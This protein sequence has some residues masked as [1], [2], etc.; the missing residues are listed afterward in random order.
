MDKD[1]YVIRVYESPL[2]LEGGEW[3]ALLARQ[4]RPTPFMRHE[5]L[6]ALH[7]SGSATPDTGWTPRFLALRDAGGV[8][9]A[10]C[11]LYFKRHS[12]GE[13]VFDWGW[14]EAYARHGLPY[15]PKAVVAVPFTPVPGSRLLAD[16]D[17]WR[18][19]LAEAARDTCASAGAS[20]L[21]L[22][23]GSPEDIT[24]CLQAGLMRRQTVQFHW[25]NRRPQP[26]DSFED[27]LAAL[28][29]DKR[30]KIRQER[31]KVQAAGVTVQARVGDGIRAQDWDFFYACYSRT[32]EEHGNPPYL[33]RAFFGGLAREQAR[34]WVLFTA[35]LEGR[36]IACSLVAFDDAPGVSAAWGRY[37]GAL[38]RVDCLH[39]ELCYYAPLQ[40][41]IGR[42]LG[43][44]EGGAQGEHKLARAL[45]PEQTYSAHWIADPRFAAAIEAFLARESEGMDGYYQELAAHSPL[46]TAGGPG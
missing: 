13:Y 15:Y 14:A 34:H 18:A 5:Y 29:Q 2:E 46:R 17:V 1:D 16:G 37:W 31:R 27:F 22:L 12:R 7:A 25:H 23:F 30:K 3:N 33:T 45:L 8:L 19:R 24:T 4:S 9:R 10:A 36:P 39:F 6:A 40:W 28:Q 11:P 41:C 43:R 35:S 42:G 26:Y 32:Y 38:E 21:H 20:S 44:F